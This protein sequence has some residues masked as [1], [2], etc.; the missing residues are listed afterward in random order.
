MPTPVNP[1]EFY[2]LLIRENSFLSLV[3]SSI[4]AAVTSK[5]RIG[6]TRIASPHQREIRR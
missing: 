6:A 1:E 5:R 3:D 2:L 4:A